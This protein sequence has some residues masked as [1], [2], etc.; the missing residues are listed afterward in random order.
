M[1]PYDFES[2]NYIPSTENDFNSSFLERLFSDPP[3]SEE[4]FN[5]FTR[6]EIYLHER[7]RVRSFH[8]RDG[9][10]AEAE[11][12]NTAPAPQNGKKRK[13]NPSQ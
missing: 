2:D 3:A 12:E 11:E 8:Q 6:E 9:E 1:D 7:S 13:A 10:N 4:E 5:G